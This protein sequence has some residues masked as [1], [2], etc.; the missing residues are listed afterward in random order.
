MASVSSNKLLVCTFFSEFLV[1]FRRLKLCVSDRAQKSL[2]LIGG[3]PNYEPV[4]GFIPPEETARTWQ[5]SQDGKLWACALPSGY[6]GRTRI[7]QI[8]HSTLTSSTGSKSMILKRSR[9][10]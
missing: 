10:R 5:Y 7:H 6:V 2:G 1:G 3:L 8:H 4:E 9:L